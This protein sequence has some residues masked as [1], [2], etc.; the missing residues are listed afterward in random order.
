MKASLRLFVGSVLVL[1]VHEVLVRMMANGHVAHALLASSPSIGAALL[2]VAL[3]VV[4]FC[5]VVLVP[6]AL[7][8][9]VVLAV[10]HYLVGSKSTGISEELADG[11]GTSIGV[12]GTE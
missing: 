10:A 5:A 2:A 8:T 1:V 6:G 12:S 3:V 11:A 7:A 4:R 9:A